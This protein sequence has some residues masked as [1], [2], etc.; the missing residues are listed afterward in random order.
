MNASRL[1]DMGRRIHVGMCAAGYTNLALLARRIGVSRQTVHR[2]LYEPGVSIGAVDAFRLADTLHLSARWI[3]L[4][5][6]TPTPR[7]SVSPEERALL[8]HYRQ[9]PVKHR[10]ILLHAA[11]DLAST[12]GR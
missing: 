4:D 9:T 11:A 3:V 8:A 2:W 10:S 6:S 7:E 12:S 5:G 1:T